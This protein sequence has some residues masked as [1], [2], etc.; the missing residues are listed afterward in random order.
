MFTQEVL[1]VLVQSTI[2]A[3][4]ERD[5][6]CFLTHSAKEEFEEVNNNCVLSL[7]PEQRIP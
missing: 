6:L 5:E 4:E 2:A 7:R 1:L 3:L